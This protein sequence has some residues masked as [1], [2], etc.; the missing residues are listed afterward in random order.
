MGRAAATNGRRRDEDPWRAGG[1]P[2]TP[3]ASAEGRSRR[4]TFALG[5]RPLRTRRLRR[6][7]ALLEQ[8]PGSPTTTSPRGD[9]AI[10]LGTHD[11]VVRGSVDYKQ[12]PGEVARPL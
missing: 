11:L 6:L 9:L 5:N 1:L 3:Q 10:V 7:D 4:V 8:R 12:S 2:Q